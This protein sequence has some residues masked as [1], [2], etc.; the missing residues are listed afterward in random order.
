MS[1]IKTKARLWAVIIA[2]FL[3]F[4]LIYRIQ[5]SPGLSLTT[6][7][8]ILPM[9]VFFDVVLIG[10][11][12]KFLWKLPIIKHLLVAFPNLNGTWKG[13][14]DSTWIDP[15]TNKKP[16]LIP[17][18]LTIKQSFLKTSCVMRTDEMTSRSITSNFMLDDDN[19]LCK[20][21]YRHR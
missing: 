12:V 20:L 10:L 4:Y 15:E 7:F 19:Q 16:A 1:N 14:I 3:I 21:V 17:A 13:H 2:S 5:G 11:F 8:P 6:I 18:I 9:V